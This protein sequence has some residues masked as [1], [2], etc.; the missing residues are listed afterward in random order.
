MEARKLK[1]RKTSIIGDHAYLS[2]R[3]GLGNRGAP[4]RILKFWLVMGHF[5][6]PVSMVFPVIL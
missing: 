1:L 6:H 3:E 2:G 5:F 4:G